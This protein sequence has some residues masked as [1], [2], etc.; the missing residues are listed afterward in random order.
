ML[1][2]ISSSI[3]QNNICREV[4]IAVANIIMLILI[5][6]ALINMDAKEIEFIYAN[7]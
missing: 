5:I 2:K 6:M 1:Q 4:L 7:F 3:M